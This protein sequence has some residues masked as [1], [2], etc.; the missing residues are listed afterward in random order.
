[1][2][3]SPMANQV[4]DECKALS[5]EIT[6]RLVKLDKL[7]GQVNELK[8][9]NE[10]LNTQMTELRRQVFGLLGASDRYHSRIIAMLDGEWQPLP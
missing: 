7:N 6:N 2:R 4:L 3:E 5:D 9:Q 10:P 8:A 1:M